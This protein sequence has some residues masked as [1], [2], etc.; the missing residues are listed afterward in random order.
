MFVFLANMMMLWTSLGALL[1]ELIKPKAGYDPAQPQRVL[2][3]QE[4][5]E[6]VVLHLPV[7]FC[8]SVGV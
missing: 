3:P 2:F 1:L 5:E 7:G 6:E 8:V 4:L